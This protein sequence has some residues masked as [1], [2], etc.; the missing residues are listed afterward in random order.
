MSFGEPAP[1]P[2]PPPLPDPLPTPP[3][4]ASGGMRGGPAGNANKVPSFGGTL[5][6][7]GEGV[8]APSSTTKKSLLG[9]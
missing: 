1:R 7:S 3:T 9:L 8:T 6:T 2:T 4:L 5:L